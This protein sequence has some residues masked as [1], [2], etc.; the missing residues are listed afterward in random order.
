LDEDVDVRALGREGGMNVSE[1]LVRGKIENVVPLLF[2]HESSESL[3]ELFLRFFSFAIER[4][5]VI[6]DEKMQMF[7]GKG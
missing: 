4:R 6:G 3:R 7:L 1:I 2:P 5:Y